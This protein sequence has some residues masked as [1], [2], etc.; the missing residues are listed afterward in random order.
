MVFPEFAM[1]RTNLSPG[2]VAE[3]VLDLDLRSLMLAGVF[4]EV[5]M[6][7]TEVASSLSDF[8]TLA[9]LSSEKSTTGC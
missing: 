8:F 9:S 1:K 6:F 5:C 4:N 2:G 3:R 7:L